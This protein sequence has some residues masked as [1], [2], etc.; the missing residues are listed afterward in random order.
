MMPNR[1]IFPL[2]HVAPG[3][4]SIL[5]RAFEGKLVGRVGQEDGD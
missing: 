1:S 5:K 3:G 4:G 2:R